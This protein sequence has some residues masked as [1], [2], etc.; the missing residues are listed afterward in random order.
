MALQSTSETDYPYISISY[1]IIGCDSGCFLAWDDE[2]GL[3]MPS[4]IW[5]G[6]QWVDEQEIAHP[7]IGAESIRR[8]PRRIGVISQGLI[9]SGS[10]ICEHLLHMYFECV[11]VDEAGHGVGSIIIAFI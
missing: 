8:C 4:A 9:T 2:D 10:E 6:R 7:G 1:N 5:D 3:G 11:I